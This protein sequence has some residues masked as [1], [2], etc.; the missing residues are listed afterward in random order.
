MGGQRHGGIRQHGL[1][2]CIPI[3]QQQQQ[4]SVSHPQSTTPHLSRKKHKLISTLSSPNRRLVST[5]GGTCSLSQPI[6]R[7]IVADTLTISFE[8]AFLGSA[9]GCTLYATA[10]VHSSCV[11]PSFSGERGTQAVTF[12]TAGLG[13]SVASVGQLVNFSLSCAAG[14]GSGAIKIENLSLRAC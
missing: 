2:P 4:I 5:S 14:A 12:S 1:R 3:H 8:W 10:G 9:T 6:T 13:V 11:K 7:A